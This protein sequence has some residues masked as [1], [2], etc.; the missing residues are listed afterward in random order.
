VELDNLFGHVFAV[1]LFTAAQP[2]LVGIDGGIMLDGLT[3]QA[4]QH[5]AHVDGRRRCRRVYAPHRRP[6]LTR[7]RWR[8][9]LRCDTWIIG[10]GRFFHS[11]LWRRCCHRWGDGWHADRL[12]AAGV[13]GALGRRGCW[14]GLRSWGEGVSRNAGMLL[15]V[16]APER[17]A[18]P[19]AE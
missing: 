1:D 7:A 4:A 11:S 18:R 13:I 3:V 17:A 19:A 6:N 5:Q 10:A 15:F 16:M 14:H 9:R 8:E 2:S 12:N